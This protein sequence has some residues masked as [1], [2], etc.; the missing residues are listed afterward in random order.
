MDEHLL[1]IVRSCRKDGQ[2]YQTLK[3]I[4]EILQDERDHFQRYLDLVERVVQNDSEA[5][6]ITET[7]SGESESVIAYVNA[8]FTRMTGFGREEVVGLTPRIL[9][10]KRTDPSIQFQMSQKLAEGESFFGE[11]INYRKDGSDFVNL[12]DVHPLKNR[13]GKVTHWISYLQ[14]VTEK[15][16]LERQF[17]RT[18][19]EWDSLSEENRVIAIDLDRDGRF[20]ATSS[21]FRDMIQCNREE[22]ESLRLQDLL[23][24]EESA[25]FSAI[26]GETAITDLRDHKVD[27]T[28]VTGQSRNLDV[29][30]HI[31]RIS[32]VERGFRIRFS[33]RSLHRRI[34]Q[35]LVALQ[36]RPLQL[37]GRLSMV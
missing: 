19:F 28:L 22:L 27:L 30:A 10:G 36:Q 1:N 31:S 7:T 37:N 3:Q 25:L 20:I 13:D 4:V 12:W 35:A 34:D 21:A 33:N 11:T 26:I 8:G 5:V 32:N 18:M 2:S 17:Q 14:D 9:H 29:T 16:S 15:R 6:M 23:S 24:E